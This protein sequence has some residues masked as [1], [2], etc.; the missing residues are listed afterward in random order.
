MLKLSHWNY[1]PS[2]KLSGQSVRRK[3]NQT[4]NVPSDSTF[5]NIFGKSRKPKKFISNHRTYYLSDKFEVENQAKVSG[6]LTP[7]SQIFMR[8][9]QIT[10][11][12]HHSRKKLLHI[13]N[14][15]ECTF[16]LT[17]VT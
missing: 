7:I 10:F 16:G 4:L 17:P 15:A 12:L 1:N 11:I 13:E 3:E 6:G 2:V 9:V 14:Q 8:F 5:L